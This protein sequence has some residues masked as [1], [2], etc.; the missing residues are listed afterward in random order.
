MVYIASYQPL[1]TF[2]WDSYILLSFLQNYFQVFIKFLYLYLII[3]PSSS[4]RG[5]PIS[6]W[7]KIGNG[8]IQVLPYLILSV[9]GNAAC[10]VRICD[11]SEKQRYPVI[12]SSSAN[13]RCKYI[14]CIV[15][16]AQQCEG[17]V[18]LTIWEE[19]SPL[20]TIHNTS[21]LSLNV[22]SSKSAKGTFLLTF[23]FFVFSFELILFDSVS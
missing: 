7:H 11:L 13:S 16:T 3:I 6:K 22:I 20:I 18:F 4:F 17:Q 23:I 8:D 1:G 19:T 14:P 10:P 2:Y 12:F 5:Q 15:I 9:D 21:Q